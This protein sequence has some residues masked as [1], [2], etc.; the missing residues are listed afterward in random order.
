MKKSNWIILAIL[1]VACGFFLW[2]W[3]YL[4][5]NLVDNPLDLVI[6]IVWWAVV[7]ALVFGIRFVEKKRQERIRTAYLAPDYLFN[8][9]VGLVSLEGEVSSV[10]ALQRL[11]GDL[12]Y[13]FD[14]ADA[15]ASDQVSFTH[16]VRTKK[17]NDGGDTWEGEVVLVDSPDADPLAFS[18]RNE[19]FN[20]VEGVP[21]P[22]DSTPT[23][24]IGTATTVP[25]GA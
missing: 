10:M 19:L 5:F 23:S 18:N 6:A 21:L 22:V 16:V 15:P 12:K 24:G 4:D 1:A 14:R 17:F 7:I 3:Y 2:L 13:N 8:S 11:L 20:I 9:E 25:V